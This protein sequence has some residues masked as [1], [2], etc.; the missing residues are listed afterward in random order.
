L[1]LISE[2]QPD[3]LLG[4]SPAREIGRD[5]VALEVCGLPF[6]IRRVVIPLR[7]L[8][9]GLHL[10]PFVGGA[11]PAG[12][13]VGQSLGCEGQ[14]SVQTAQLEANVSQAASDLGPLHFG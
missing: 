12:R 11:Q 6:G 3:F 14:V 4:L 8:A 13:G 7:L 5:T 10:S 1:S 2:L 9:P